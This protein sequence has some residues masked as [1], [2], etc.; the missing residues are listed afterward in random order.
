MEY[1][2]S[3]VVDGASLGVKSRKLIIGFVVCINQ[4]VVSFIIKLWFV[5]VSSLWSRTPL[6]VPL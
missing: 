4:T 3:R 6:V 1:S 5:S 2:P